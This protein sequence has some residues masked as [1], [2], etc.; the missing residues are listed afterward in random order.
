MR[1]LSRLQDEVESWRKLEARVGDAVELAELGDEDMA[2][3]L[4]SGGL[5]PL[6]LAYEHADMEAMEDVAE[7]FRENFDRLVVLGTGGSSLGG[8]A[9]TSALAAVWAT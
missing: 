3:E 7:H 9:L 6:G 2:A 4:S 1:S 8:Q 5:A